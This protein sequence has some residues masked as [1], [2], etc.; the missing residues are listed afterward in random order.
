MAATGIVYM[1]FEESITSL[2]RSREGMTSSLDYIS[3]SIMGIQIGFIV[4]AIIITRSS[5]ASLQAK[6]GLPLGSQVIGW[7][8][9][10]A[11]LDLLFV[12]K[13]SLPSPPR[14]H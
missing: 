10:I 14:R 1:L 5:I 13:Q 11:S 12:H 6:K 7:F 3:R 9:L 8:T 2:S 4:L